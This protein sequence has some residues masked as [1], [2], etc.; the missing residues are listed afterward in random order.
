MKTF[1]P[2]TIELLK[3]RGRHKSYYLASPYTAPT[4]ETQLQ[5]AKT[6]YTITGL[7]LQQGLLVFSPI[8]YCHPFTVDFTLPPDY[9]F[10]LDFNRG[11]IEAS[12]GI[13]VAQLNGWR[14]SKGVAQEIDL[15]KEIGRPIYY[16]DPYTMTF[17][18]EPIDPSV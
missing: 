8:V 14:Q 1:E 4:K 11:H 12:P 3:E 18:E 17:S 13:I 7:L 9:L 2:I 10:W 15:A 5:R 16:Y 6:V